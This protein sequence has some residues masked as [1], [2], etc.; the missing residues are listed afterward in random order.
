[1]TYVIKYYRNENTTNR[2]AFSDELKAAY[3]KYAS[4]H[5][6]SMIKEGFG[7]SEK[8]ILLAGHNSAGVSLLK[9]LLE[10]APGGKAQRGLENVGIWM[11]EEQE[12]GSFELKMYND[13]PYPS[14]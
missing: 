6:I 1:M 8:S 14:K 12:D 3:T 7:G 10:E 11:A 5:A 4:N 2:L 9:L 13:Q